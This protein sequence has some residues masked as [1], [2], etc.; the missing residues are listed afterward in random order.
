MKDL[1]YVIVEPSGNTWK[2]R[3]TVAVYSI[4]GWKYHHWISKDKLE[5]I[6]KQQ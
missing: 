4:F 2:Q 5:A 6:I 3:L 1:Y